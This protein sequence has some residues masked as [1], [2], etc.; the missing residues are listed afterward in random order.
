MGDYLYCSFEDGR[1]CTWGLHHHSFPMLLWD[2]LVQTGYGD[3][4]PEYYGWLFEEYGLQRYEVYVEIPS[5]PMF[6][7]GSPWSTW[8]IGADMSDAMEKVSH[9]TLTTLCSQNLPATTGTLISLYPIQGRSDPEWKACMDEARNL[10]R[11]HHCS[12]WTYMAHYAQ[13]LF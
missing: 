4:P 5:H 10:H 7:D 3:T 12:G 8:A 1:L 11:V 2:T 6:L 13:H 9:M